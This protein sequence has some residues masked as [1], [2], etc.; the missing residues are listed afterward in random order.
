MK[1][2]RK[3]GWFETVKEIENFVLFTPFKTAPFS[4][5]LLLGKNVPLFTTW[6][7]SDIIG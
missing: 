5:S 2:K 1:S 6:I 7:E 3:L 4:L